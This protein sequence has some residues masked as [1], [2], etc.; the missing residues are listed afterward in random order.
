MVALKTEIEKRL[1]LLDYRVFGSTARGDNTRGSDI[2][3]MI[4]VENYTPE[5]ESLIDDLVFQINIAHDCLISVIIFSSK[6]LQEGPLRESPIYRS[7]S[8]EGIRI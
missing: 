7:I 6:E 3:V 8:E 4:E 1:D 2:D 5:V